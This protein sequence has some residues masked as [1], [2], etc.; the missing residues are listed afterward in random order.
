[1]RDQSTLEENNLGE[2]KALAD[3]TNRCISAL[4]AN[5]FGASTKFLKTWRWHESLPY[6]F[7]NGAKYYHKS[8][9]KV[10]KLMVL[11]KELI[12]RD[13]VRMKEVGVA[14]QQIQVLEDDIKNE[15]AA[16]VSTRASLRK[17]KEELAYVEERAKHLQ[18]NLVQAHALSLYAI[19]IPGDC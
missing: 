10:S 4:S 15:R 6:W 13:L 3:L 12:N 16:L 9:T 1:M 5:S 8:W 17:T 11:S 18:S 2:A 14:H 19:S 7:Y